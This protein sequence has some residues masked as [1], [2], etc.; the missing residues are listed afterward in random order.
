MFRAFFLL[1]HFL[2]LKNVKQMQEMKQLEVKQLAV[3]TL[4]TK[5]SRRTIGHRG[6]GVILSRKP[7][8][9]GVHNL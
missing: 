8:V 7:A 5:L 6:V 2:G 1:F 9:V 4:S 3:E